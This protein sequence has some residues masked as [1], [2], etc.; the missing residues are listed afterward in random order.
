MSALLHQFRDL[1]L[2]ALLHGAVA[3]ILALLSDAAL[4]APPPNADPVLHQWFETQHS[5][6]GAWCCDVS[7]GHILDDGDWR[8][9]GI[10]YAVRISGAW[11]PV[12][13]DALRDPKGGPNPTGHAIVWFV[14]AEVPHIYCFAPGFEL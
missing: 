8:A 9:D 2:S 10:G 4:G 12:P 13:S 1:R 3:A 5:A 6:G 11:W 7:D 14:N